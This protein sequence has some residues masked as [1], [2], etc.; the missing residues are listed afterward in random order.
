MK[1][2]LFYESRPEWGG[3]QKCE[4]E[5]L[6]HLEKYGFKTFF[7]SSTDGPMIERIKK[8]G[9]NFVLFPVSERINRVRKEHVVSGRVRYFSSFLALLPHYWHVAKYLLKHS[10]D[11]VYTSQFRSQLVVAWLAKVLRKKV[12]W[13]IHGEES[14]QNMLGK[15]AVL[16]SDRIIVVS[17]RI[18]KHYQDMF[19]EYQHKFHTVYNGISLDAVK[20]NQ[21]KTDI[22][23]LVI[24]G[25]LIEEKRQDLAI[26]ACAQLKEL[27]FPIRLDI[28]GEKPPWKS[29]E[30]K[31]RLK[32]LVETYELSGEVSFLGWIEQPQQILSQAHIFLLPSDTEGMPL[33]IL[34]AMSIGLPCVATDVGGVSELIE[35]GETGFVVNKG[36]DR[37]LVHA[38][39]ALIENEHL[40]LQM[41]QKS[42]ERYEKLFTKEKFLEGVA[43]VLH[44]L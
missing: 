22:Y 43:R 35:H 34:E 6:L 17:D 30:Y 5:L 32:R 21:K 37:E 1:K 2:V 4:L 9:K 8:N 44:R 20:E 13:H 11:V 28:V 7:L 33:S 15:L 3:A 29:N 40:R 18:C 10:I 41:G 27:G 12:V 26:K 25:T 42:K 24:V 19:P 16:F 38:L 39:R 23:R 36:D 14:L 31:D